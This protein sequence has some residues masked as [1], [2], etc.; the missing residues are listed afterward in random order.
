MVGVALG[1]HHSLPP[2]MVREGIEGRLFPIEAQLDCI[3]RYVSDI[4][5][6]K[7]ELLLEKHFGRQVDSMGVFIRECLDQA[8][9]VTDVCGSFKGNEDC[10]R[11]HEEPGKLHKPVEHFVG[12]APCQQPL[13]ATRTEPS[14]ASGSCSLP[15]VPDFPDFPACGL[16]E[17]C[18]LISPVDLQAIE[19]VQ[20][21]RT[22]SVCSSCTT[23]T[24]GIADAM[25][26]A[27][28]DRSSARADVFVGSI[29][30]PRCLTPSPCTGTTRGIAE[31]VA[32]TLADPRCVRANGYGCSTS[33][34]ASTASGLRFA[35]AHGIAVTDTQSL[36]RGTSTGA[37]HGNAEVVSDECA[38]PG[39]AGAGGC[40]GENMLLIHEVARRMPNGA[41]RFWRDGGCVAL[42]ALGVSI[43]VTAGLY[44]V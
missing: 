7:F 32:D 5:E 13:V 11:V 4:L 14:V 21:L 41:K 20:E 8:T 1:H 30:S 17:D 42:R 25:A 43:R 15:L 12:A 3:L 22:L 44:F 33:S 37:A 24:R 18:H 2:S 6:D 19:S 28:A 35:A 34:P 29:S 16:D 38:D 31:A 36:E 23:A 10:A 26:A 40:Y 27:L 9:C 39:G